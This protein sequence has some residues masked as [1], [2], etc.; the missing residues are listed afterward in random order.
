MECATMF[1]AHLNRRLRWAFPIKFCRLRWY[2]CLRILTFL[3][4]S[5]EQ[6]SQFQTNFAKASF[7]PFIWEIINICWTFLDI[8][9]KPQKRHSQENWNLYGALSGTFDSSL[10]DHLSCLSVCPFSH[11][12]HLVQNHRANFNQ[13]CHKAP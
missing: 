8:F 6:L 9:Q 4:F 10:L 12:Q 3:I 5:F 13:I 2:C 7:V 11:F 1:L